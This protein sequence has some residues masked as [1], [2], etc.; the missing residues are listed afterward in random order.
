MNPIIGLK[1][2]FRAL[3]RNGMRPGLTMLGII[4]GV[5][6]VIAMVAVGQGAKAQVEA[7]IVSIG[8]NML[9]VYPGS[10]TQGGVR[11]SCD[12]NE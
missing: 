6:A 3:T 1:I 11:A 8:S 5:G 2:A 4:I 10:T 9:M 12:R 7:Q